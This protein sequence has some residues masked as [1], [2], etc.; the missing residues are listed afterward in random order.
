MF[1]TLQTS[2]IILILLSNT[3]KAED[4]VYLLK[5]TPS[6]YTGFLLPSSKVQELKNNT[7]QLQGCN[8]NITSYQQ[9]LSIC[10][11]MNTHY[12][13]SDKI[14]STQN[15]ALAKQLQAAQST[16]DVQKI[17]YFGAGVLATILVL[18]GVKKVSQ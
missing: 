6:P 10:Q 3:L 18:Y 7:I 2:L 4:S 15:D 12:Q 13:D 9:S 16:S 14:Y 17:L 5:N 1:K 8:S 11:D